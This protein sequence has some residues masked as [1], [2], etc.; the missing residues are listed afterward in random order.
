M[1]EFM[2]A[3]YFPSALGVLAFTIFIFIKGLEIAKKYQDEDWEKQ[4]EEWDKKWQLKI[5]RIGQK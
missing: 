4:R 2:Q 1:A 5:Q 3:M